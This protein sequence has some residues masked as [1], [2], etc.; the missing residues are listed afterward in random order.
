VLGLDALHARDGLA[1][2]FVPALGTCQL[3]TSVPHLLAL[4]PAAAAGTGVGDR[5]GFYSSA[6]LRSAGVPA[7]ARRATLPEPGSCRSRRSRGRRGAP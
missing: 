7:R 4:G 1:R 2:A 5:V 3:H 6:H